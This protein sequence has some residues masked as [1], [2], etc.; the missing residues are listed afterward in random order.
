MPLIACLGW[1]SLVWDPRS[2][3]VQREWFTDGPFAPVEFLRQSQDGRITLVLDPRVD[4]VPVRLLWA[5]M[6]HA[7][8]TGAREA[9]RAR[10]GTP[11]QQIERDIGAW[12]RGDAA[13]AWIAALPHW[14]E[15]HG[16]EGVVWTALPPKFNGQVGETP[17]PENLV[18]YL[19]QLT[20]RVRED[21]ERYVRRAPRQIDT[22][23]RRRIEAAMQWTPL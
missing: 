6:D 23:Y 1:G 13:P 8:L 19:A 4:A 3:A 7:D 20:G 11:P 22:P 17:T 5:V 12:S 21:A 10:E 18:A 15:S 2:L 14:A 9:L 16:V